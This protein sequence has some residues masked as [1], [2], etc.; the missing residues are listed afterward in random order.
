MLEVVQY[1]GR[2]QQHTSKPFVK[3]LLKLDA[4][5]LSHPSRRSDD[6]SIKR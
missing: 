4:C 1:E 5:N 2:V 3:F 6:Q